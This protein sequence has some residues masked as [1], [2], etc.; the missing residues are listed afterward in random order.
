V[1]ARE[2][3][4]AAVFTCLPSSNLENDPVPIRPPSARRPPV[5]P[6][7][8][9]L[10]PLVGRER[11]VAAVVALLRRDDGRLVTLTGPGGV[12]KT[13]LAIASA[14]VVGCAFV[15]GV[16]FVA[17]AAVRDPA[18]V[19]VALARALGLGDGIG[20]PADRLRG[21]LRQQSALL[22]LDNF[23]HLL[24]AAP[25]LV[26]LLEG[27]PGLNILATSREPLHLYGEH[28]C[29]VP[30]LVLPHSRTSSVDDLAN[31]EA[32]RLFVLRASAVDGGFALSEGN[33]A[34]V[35]E[36]CLR[37]DGLPLAIELA[38]ARVAHL[39]PEA[40]LCRLD[41]RLPLLTK[42]PQDQPPRLRTM[43]DAIAWS[44]D[45]LSPEE[46]RLFR[47]MAVFV[48][49]GQLDAVAAVCGGPWG[50][51][52]GPERAAIGHHPAEIPWSSLL[53]LLGSLV[54]RSL[55]QR[56]TPVDRDPRFGM[57]E[58]VREFA[59]EEL[60]AHGELEEA[61]RRHALHFRALAEGSEGARVGSSVGHRADVLAGERANLR[62]ALDWLRLRGE[63]GLALGMASSLWPLWLERGELTL[64]R[65]YLQSLMGLPD[66][67]RDR[68]RWAKSAWVAGALAQAQG[69]H[70]RAVALSEEALALAR[71]LGDR[72]SAAAALTTLGL[73]ALVLGDFA[74]AEANLAEG[75]ALFEADGDVRAG[76]W[77]MRHLG[78]VAYR[79]HDLARAAALADAGLVV[80]RAGG[81]PVDVARLLHNR[82]VTEA[83]RGDLAKAVRSWEEALALYR[84]AGDR[85]GEADTLSSL[86]NAAR[87]RGEG[88]AGTLLAESL[89]LF[90]EVGDPEGTALV[91]ERI[92]WLAR[93]R[94]EAEEAA[95]RFD[96]GLALARG[97]GARLLAAELL[98]GCGAL[99][100]DRGDLS[101]AAASWGE[102]IRLASELR[103]Q[104]CIVAALAWIA[105]LAAAIGDDGVG[106]QLLGAARALR[107]AVGVPV[108]PPERE[109]QER[110]A[111]ALRA[112]LGPERF[113]RAFDDG[114]AESADAAVAEAGALALG[115]AS[116]ADLALPRAEAAGQPLSAR[117]QEV[118]RLVAEGQ[119]DKDIALALAIS[120]RTAT[121]HVTHILGKLD[122]ESR[123]AAAAVAVRRGLA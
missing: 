35:A 94:G 45:L 85:W 64:G 11:E 117:E 30:P 114:R 38:A 50:E 60:V 65:S 13:R 59:L 7:P 47:R 93:R 70:E 78:T 92:G 72:R 120:Y 67:A 77:A 46:Q 113:A 41:R 40:M 122:V 121:T 22:L 52:G 83:A 1:L 57:L 88:R 32:V 82:G 9:P 12:G 2:A 108:S 87:L 54:D 4:G 23:E 17:L 44:Y 123:A 75:L 14:T 109:E 116:R 48:G 89:A 56:E 81:D 119:S 27:C 5:A 111:R 97:R 99:A 10:T 66:A 107:D 69:D 43:R 106:A 26:D 80:A 91:L 51:A 8:R 58:T 100:F 15:D 79:R 28:V 53:D 33:A 63:T 49:G 39:R 37:L 34:T 105:H 36:I 98:C 103:D 101:R 18:L 6:L 118:L 84:D 76:A 115:A 74:R 19:G 25:F 112:R 90:R 73:V 21:A 16:R 95:R 3:K 104:V 24:G 71:D 42:G 68:A 96:E 62:S 86:G 20:S 31:A 55:L 102:A 61:Q 110:L 29:R